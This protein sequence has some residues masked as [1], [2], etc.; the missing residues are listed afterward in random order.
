MRLQDLLGAGKRARLLNWQQPP[1]PGRWIVTVYLIQSPVISVRVRAYLRT[2]PLETQQRQLDFS[3]IAEADA[4][5]DY[6]DAWFDPDT[7]FLTRTS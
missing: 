6:S 5:F 1:D 3:S 2:I 7:P 4:Y